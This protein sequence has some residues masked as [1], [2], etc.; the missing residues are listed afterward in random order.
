MATLPDV[1]FKELAAELYVEIERRFP[2]IAAD[3]ERVRLVALENSFSHQ[4]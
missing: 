1:R 2:A 3:F 4:H